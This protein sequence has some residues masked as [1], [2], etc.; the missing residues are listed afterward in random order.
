MGHGNEGIVEDPK[1]NRL[2]FVASNDCPIHRFSLPKDESFECISHN[3]NQTPLA[4][5]TL[6]ENMIP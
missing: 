4:T 5:P 3:E 2:A 1:V 6:P